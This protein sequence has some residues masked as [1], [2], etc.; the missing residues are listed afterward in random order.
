M[1]AVT[2]YEGYIPADGDVYPISIRGCAYDR[3]T[4]VLTYGQRIEVKNREV[5]QSF[6]PLLDG[7]SMPAQLIAM[8]KGDAVELTRS[9]SVTTPF[10]KA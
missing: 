2:G 8:P 7:S 1:V 6:L 3:R 10:A 5:K 4:L 9:R